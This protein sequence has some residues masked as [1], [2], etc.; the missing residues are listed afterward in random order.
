LAET[1]PPCARAVCSRARDGAVLTADITQSWRVE[2]VFD[3]YLANVRRRG[4]T[5]FAYLMGAQWIFA[6]A[7]AVIISPRA[8]AGREGSVHTHV[9]A[10]VFLGGAL[11]ALPILA[12]LRQHGAAQNGFV[13]AVAQPMWSALLIHLTGGR[14]ETHFHVFGSLAFL[15]FYRDWRL[16]LPATVV[17]AGDHL[18]RGMLWP[19]S[20][21][22]ISNPEWWRFVEHALWV[23]FEDIVLAFG[24][25]YGVGELRRLA[26]QQV[27]RDALDKE[28][29]AR[30]MEV[31]N[32]IQTSILP[33]KIAVP[34][35]D[36]G[37]R[38][39][40]ATEVGGDYYD[41]IPTGSD[42]CWIGVG[43]VAGHGLPAGI[44][45]LMI[46]SATAALV[47]ADPRAAPSKHVARLNEVVFDNIH[48]RLEQ[49]EHCTFT[50]LHV[51][52]DGRVIMAGAHE[53]VVIRRAAT[54]TCEQVETRGAWI[55]GC[56]D[57][58]SE[59]Q[60]FT[61]A[62]GDVM[63][64]YTDGITEA[65][66]AAREHFGI[67]RVCATVEKDGATGVAELTDRILAETTRWLAGAAAEDDRTVVVVRYLG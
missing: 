56:A 14:I 30:E 42:G 37:A 10:A 11:S 38:M 58:C 61:L 32:R 43:D 9:Y 48:N 3:E 64:L 23:V 27:A 52:K 7:L 63:V 1:Q 36:I 49:D 8:W 19:E 65:R 13:M 62:A 16:L 15:A 45:M 40:T 53:D 28:R 25:V 55:G 2:E 33:K 59:D 35:L 29:L 44:V 17:V 51:T 47:R 20:V 12:V 41:V 4:D 24:C 60:S 50:L 57:I 46:Q 54:G 18:V 31:A 26:E 6:I 5:I 21:Y 66:N 22:G 34:G 67:D 39:V